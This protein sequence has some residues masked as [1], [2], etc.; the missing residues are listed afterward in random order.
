MTVQ[1]QVYLH[2]LPE[3]D[4]KGT[5]AH[6]KGHLFEHLMRRLLESLKITITHT[7]RSKNGTEIDIQG[8]HFVSKAPVL[9]ECKATDSPIS[10]ED[11]QKFGYKFLNEREDNRNTSGFF[12]TISGLNSKA[13][14]LWDDELKQRYGDALTKYEESELVDLIIEHLQLCPPQEI[15]TAAKKD[16]SRECGDS[17][18]YCVD[19]QNDDPQLF[20][21]QLLMSSDG[22]QPSFVAFYTAKG[23]L[24]QTEA[25]IKRLWELNPKLDNAKLECLN[26]RKQ[27]DYASRLIDEVSPSRTVVRV[28]RSK[29]WFD[30]RFP[31]APEFFVGRTTQRSDLARFIMD[32]HANKTSVRGVFFSGK[33]GIGKSSLA[34]KSQEELLSLDTLLLP[35]DSRLCDD[36]SF[37]FDSVNELLFELRKSSE[38]RELL[39]EVRVQGFDSLIETL[40]GIHSVLEQEGKYAILFFDQFER[41]FDYPEIT[42]SI[43]NLFLRSTERQ[44]RVLFGFAWKSDLWSQAEGFPHSERDDIARESFALSPLGQFGQEETGEIISQL[45]VQWGEKL[46]ALFKGQ[47]AVFSRGLPW[48]L[49]K[50]CAHALEQKLK[51]ATQEELIETNLKLQDLFES[52]LAGLDDEERAL[53]KAIAPLL[54]TSLRRLSESF[55]IAHIDRALHRFI[56]RRILV[57]IT[58][59]VG[60][61]YANVKY[62]AYSDIFREFLVTGTIPLEEAYYFFAYPKGGLAFFQKVKLLGT[63]SIEQEIAET[64]KQIASVYNLSRDLRQL[65]LLEINKKVFTVPDEVASLSE[66]ELTPYLQR[67]L[68]QN[69]LV[70]LALA[71]L[72]ERESLEL[73]DIARLLQDLFP[74][75]RAKDKTW[76]HYSRTTA[77]WMH[78]AKLAYYNSREGAL[79][80]VDDEDIFEQVISRGSLRGKG[81]RFPSRFRNA[82]IDC[83]DAIKI[84]GKGIATV[85]Q[86]MEWLNKK[87]Q[88]IEMAVS[89]CLSLGFVSFDENTGLYKLTNVGARFAMESESERRDIFAEQ[90]NTVEIYRDFVKTVETRQSAGIAHRDAVEL[91][92]AG[93]DLGLADATMDKLGAILANWAEYGGVIT[94][95]GR[96]CIASKYAFHQADLFSALDD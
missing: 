39:A 73:T 53:L 67:K 4:S 58:E 15:R 91:I 72:N 9:A 52:D 66:E 81:F 78:E 17:L 79:Y 47:L 18:L 68:K 27:S 10:S 95:Y 62:D 35:I 11:L 45:E 2:I 88:S 30:Y 50:V 70:S 94:R 28:R 83:I 44:L 56:D 26:L 69:R 82:I 76:L 64:G 21:A 84:H 63:L 7:N 85:K 49:K 31:A 93:T 20:W 34:L 96:R 86:L 40:S 19:G 38:M 75:V 59:D 22:T 1:P 29:D 87:S 41:V 33:S 55:E 74:S 65:G 80:R 43:R 6:N 25:T 90:C 13:R 71:E 24:L 77:I 23:V 48:L 14:E 92:L 36:I 32:V 12:L 5:R 51:G 46:S 54:P 89:D 57:K 8:T 42:R 37:L 61:S 3:G 60:D 16:Y